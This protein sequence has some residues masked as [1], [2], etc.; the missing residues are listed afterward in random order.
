MLEFPFLLDLTYAALC[1][2]ILLKKSSGKSCLLKAFGSS[3]LFFAT[4]MVLQSFVPNI[5]LFNGVLRCRS[6]NHG[7]LA[8]VCV[9]SF[10][11]WLKPGQGDSIRKNCSMRSHS[12]LEVTSSGRGLFSH[13]EFNGAMYTSNKSPVLHR[14]FVLCYPKYSCM[15]DCFRVSSFSICCRTSNLSLST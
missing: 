1:K 11:R 4:V 13:G 9:K 5:D 14:G 6:G 10:C 3:F 2:S 7:Q 15:R 12:W 8:H